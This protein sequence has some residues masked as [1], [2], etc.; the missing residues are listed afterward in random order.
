MNF[1]KIKRTFSAGIAAVMCAVI[2]LSVPAAAK[3]TDAVWKDTKALTGASYSSTYIKLVE[4]YSEKDT[5]KT[6]TYSKSMTKKLLDKLEKAYGKDEPQF[7]IKLI[8]NEE[9]ASAAVKGDKFKATGYIDGEGMAYLGNSKNFTFLDPNDKE[10]CSMK[11]N[12]ASESKIWFPNAGEVAES[13]AELFNF[14]ISENA[15][16]KLFKFKNGE[17]IYCYEEFKD[18]N[19]GSVGFL[20]SE[21]GN[22]LAMTNQGDSFCVSVSFKV[23]DS[24]F[25]IPKDYKDVDYTDIDWLS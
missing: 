2:S 4:K 10:K 8:N 13:G 23:N 25:N 5:T 18:S 21:G 1:K 20:F 22:I 19:Y 24:E 11:I 6:V 3:N 7:T 17:K 16:G 12:K 9:I 15:K 14:D